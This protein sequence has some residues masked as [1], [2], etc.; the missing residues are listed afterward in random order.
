MATIAAPTNAYAARKA[1]TK[2]N[3]KQELTSFLF[4]GFCTG[5]WGIFGL[6]SL[7]SFLRG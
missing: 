6:L 5:A 7:Y 4:W 2:T 1:E 3:F